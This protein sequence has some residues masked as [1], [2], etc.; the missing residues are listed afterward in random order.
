M[1]QTRLRLKRKLKS[2]FCFKCKI[3]NA[4]I[5]EDKCDLY[6]RIF[7]F[8]VV[9]WFIYVSAGYEIYIP[10]IF[11]FRMPLFIFF[12]CHNFLQTSGQIYL[13]IGGLVSWVKAS[14]F[15]LQTYPKV[16]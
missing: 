11:V 4:K 6:C 16:R 3:A 13:K 10:T 8:L 1:H 14:D 15:L 5:Y 2:V 9:N 7:F 12:F